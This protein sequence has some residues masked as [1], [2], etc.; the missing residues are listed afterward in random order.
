MLRLLAIL[1]LL[2]GVVYCHAQ[3]LRSG[4]GVEVFPHFSNR[5]LLA[6]D[7]STTPQYRLDSLELAETALPSY[8]TGLTVHHRGNKVGVQAS[9]Y[10][11]RV[12]YSSQRTRIPFGDPFAAR[13]TDQQYRFLSQQIT[14]PFAILFYQELSD[15][16][17]FF[18][19]LGSG[20]SYNMKNQ[21]IIERFEGDISE[22]EIK[23]SAF[24]YRR[25][26]YSFQTGMG[27][28]HRFNENWV[29]SVTPTFSIWLAGL[30]VDEPISRNL[31]QLGVRV[32]VRYDRWFE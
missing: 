3:D 11:S 15:K 9:L 30:Y 27:W 13:F 6:F 7:L 18:F 32:G 31:Y 10:Y 8:S 19:L 14:I 25:L 22:K 24:D 29:M 28:E 4:V 12:G 1:L 20:L 16:D 26:N 2:G 5:R 21:D 17:D 23:D